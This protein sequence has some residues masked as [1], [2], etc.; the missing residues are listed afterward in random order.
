MKACSCNVVILLL[1]V[2]R[3]LK[4][5]ENADSLW[6]VSAVSIKKLLVASHNFSARKHKT[7]RSTIAELGKIKTYRDLQ[8]WSCLWR[9]YRTAP[10][11]ARNKT[12]PSVI[13]LI[14]ESKSESESDDDDGDGDDDD[15][16]DDD[17]GGCN[18]KIIK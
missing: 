7:A 10:I 18:E 11:R 12:T 14:S 3:F 17:D 9:K 13:A 1:S 8:M 15:D 6:S 2:E 5:S 4:R 16:D